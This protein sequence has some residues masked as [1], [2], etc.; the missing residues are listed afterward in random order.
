MAW[1]YSLRAR[2]S[3]TY[4]LMNNIHRTRPV[5][6]CPIPG[7]ILLGIQNNI[8]NNNNI[9][10][11]TEYMI[12]VGIRRPCRNIVVPYSTVGTHTAEVMYNGY[13]MG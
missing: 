12:W 11:V 9:Y 4:I 13:N 1:A 3:E 2:S 6:L 7:R 10:R 5:L 8:I